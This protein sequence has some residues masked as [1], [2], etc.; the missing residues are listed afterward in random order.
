MVDLG[1]E[2]D[3]TSLEVGSRGEMKL[4]VPLLKAANLANAA[5]QM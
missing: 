1:V 3:A 4:T 2:I 5:V